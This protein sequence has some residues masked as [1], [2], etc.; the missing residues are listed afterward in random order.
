MGA[1]VSVGIGA[2]AS[3]DL[4]ADV[5]TV[6]GIILVDG[7]AADGDIGTVIGSLVGPVATVAAAGEG[8]GE[9]EGEADDSAAVG[10]GLS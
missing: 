7:A 9:T 3:I 10:T 6:L 4:A 8:G 2:G 5:G 1:V